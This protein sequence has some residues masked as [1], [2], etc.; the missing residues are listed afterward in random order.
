M[1]T[2]LATLFDA[3]ARMPQAIPE[4]VNADIVLTLLFWKLM[5]DWAQ[6]KASRFHNHYHQP[7][8]HLKAIRESNQ[9]LFN[10]AC[11]YE[12]CQWHQPEHACLA[13]RDALY[14]WHALQKHPSLYSILRPERFGRQGIWFAKLSQSSHLADVITMIGNLSFAHLMPEIRIGEIFSRALDGLLPGGAV[15]HHVVP[16]L[17]IDLLQPLH[18]DLIYDPACGIGQ[19]LLACVRDMNQR[20]PRHQMQVLGQES[21]MNQWALCKMQ[22]LCHGITLHQLANTDALG[23]PML[24]IPGAPNPDVVL[25]YLPGDLKDWKHK[26][27]WSDVRFPEQPPKHASLAMIWHG[28]AQ[29]Q[30]PHARMGVIAPLKLLNNLE[31]T[32]LRRYLVEQRYLDAVIELPAHTCPGGRLGLLVLRH[33][34]LMQGV[35]FISSKAKGS[36]A[37]SRP[38]YDTTAILHAYHA[39]R[40][41]QAAPYLQVI[42]GSTMVQRD[43]SFSVADYA[44]SMANNPHRISLQT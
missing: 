11:F 42:E 26:Q 9:L 41:H 18:T 25:T 3:K 16:Q 6:D 19:L 27:G 5:S 37:R 36:G 4:D 28:L 23:Q 1:N 20:Q 15:L 40:K 22:L 44:G 8:A 24:G 34:H 29:L 17:M 39:C 21:S 14:R 33:S 38:S 2:I 13:L 35:A 7:A 31:A 10:E 30:Q 43:C 32:A 12:S